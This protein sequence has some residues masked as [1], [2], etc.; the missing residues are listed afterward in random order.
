M[1]SDLLHVSCLSRP[2]HPWFIHPK[3]IDEEYQPWNASLCICLHPLVTFFFL[4]LS[5]IST[6]LSHSGKNRDFGSWVSLSVRCD[7]IQS[8]V[9]WSAYQRNLLPRWWW[10]SSS[11]SPLIII[12]TTTTRTCHC[13]HHSYH[14]H[15]QRLGGSI[16]LWNVILLLSNDMMSNLEE[17]NL[18]SHCPWAPQISINWCS[19]S[20]WRHIQGQS[21]GDS[22]QFFILPHTLTAFSCCWYMTRVLVE[23]VVSFPVHLATY[24]LVA[25][26]Y[27][28]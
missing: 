12:I 21:N 26:F 23:R 24:P 7:T 1:H 22:F 5:I 27:I 4:G 10:W 28:Y 11:S 6:L 8:G 16:I 20:C 3:N 15:K 2:S 14:N 18:C 9:C 19:C 25:V 17:S 13:H